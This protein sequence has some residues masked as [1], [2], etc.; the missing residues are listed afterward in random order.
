LAYYEEYSRR[1]LPNFFRRWLEVAVSKETRIDYLRRGLIAMV[2]NFQDRAFSA[3]Q[4][5]KP[6]LKITQGTLNT[7][8]N[9]EMPQ[10][11]ASTAMSH[12][13]DDNLHNT[14]EASTVIRHPGSFE[15][16]MPD[17]DDMHTLFGSGFPLAQAKSSTLLDT[18][19]TETGTSR[20]CLGP[21][22][23]LKTPKENLAIKQADPPGELIEDRPND[24][25]PTQEFENFDVQTPSGVL[26]SDVDWETMLMEMS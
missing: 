4:P 6:T 3:W 17:E 13:Q 7:N 21:C 24:E 1:E 16:N 10:G 12:S 14:L 26:D 15:L 5:K 9:L 8:T 23:C 2:R 18:K 19:N 22:I 25:W 11:Q 20:Y